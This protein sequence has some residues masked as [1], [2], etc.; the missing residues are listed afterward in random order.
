MIQQLSCSTYQHRQGSRVHTAAPPQRTSVDT[1]KRVVILYVSTPRNKQLELSTTSMF[2]LSS[3]VCMICAYCDS[4]LCDITANVSGSACESAY[5]CNDAL[6][7]DLDYVD[8]DEQSGWQQHASSRSDLSATA[9]A[10]LPVGMPTYMYS[11][12]SIHIVST[13]LRMMQEQM[14]QEVGRMSSCSMRALLCIR[15]HTVVQDNTQA[16]LQLQ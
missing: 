12:E 14:M 5:H 10:A 15:A 2:K 16:S 7:D 6:S 4:F 8:L 13:Q 3:A 1:S 11:Q 9:A